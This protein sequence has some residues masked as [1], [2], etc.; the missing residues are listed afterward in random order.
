MDNCQG[1]NAAPYARKSAPS[2]EIDGLLT[3]KIAAI[4]SPTRKDGAI[5]PAEPIP[6]V[7]LAAPCGTA[8]AAAYPEPQARSSETMISV[9]TGH[10]SAHGGACDACRRG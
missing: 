3:L 9:H 7:I 5:A 10:K 2:A 4:K 6:H 8:S 1:G